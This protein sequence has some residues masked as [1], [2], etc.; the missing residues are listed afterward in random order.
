[1]KTIFMTLLVTMAGTVFSQDRSSILR[2]IEVTG[3]HELKI[4]P[5]MIY[6]N[7]NIEEYW[8]EEFEGKKWE[9]YKTKIEIE[10]I[11]NDLISELNTLGIG[12]D[13]ITLKQA[14]NY[15]RSRGKDFLIN[16][17]LELRLS[18]FEM[19]NTIS[20]TLKTRGIK[21]MNISRLDHSDM[22]LLKIKVKKEALKNAKNKAE[23]LAGVY[24]QDLGSPISI[25][26]MD[27]NMNVRPMVQTQSRAY[28]MS[29]ESS[30]NTGVQYENF[31][32]ITLKASMRIS[33][34]I[35]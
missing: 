23:Q 9:D 8:A 35:L 12:M 1:M 14:G 30:M 20:N 28:K 13:Q 16:K 29:A 2:T 24:E 25:V 32:Q 7:I 15:W 21:S 19:V 31:R 3:T 26:E 11:E 18:S 22:E 4:D 6:F 10:T 5:E 27:K 17:N 33:F 34:E